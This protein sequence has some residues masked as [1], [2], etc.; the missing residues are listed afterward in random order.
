MPRYSIEFQRSAREALENLPRDIQLRVKTAITRLAE[1]P[2]PPGSKKL[3]G[4]HNVWR[5]RIGNYRVLYAIEEYQL[6]VFVVKVG[7]RREVYR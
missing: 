7:H 4:Q 3:S 6:V 5:I 2:R 1:E